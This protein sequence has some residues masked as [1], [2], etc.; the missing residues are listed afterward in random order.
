MNDGY[1]NTDQFCLRDR[2]VME[3]DKAVASY[4]RYI[5]YN[6][7]PDAVLQLFGSSRNGFGFRNSDMDICL[8]FNG[9][10]TAEVSN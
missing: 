8:K 1:L 7:Y 2:A 6:G 10:Q 4:E 3:R 9:S 5:R